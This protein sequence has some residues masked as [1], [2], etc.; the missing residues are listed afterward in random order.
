MDCLQGWLSSKIG[1]AEVDE[2]MCPG[3]SPDGGKCTYKLSIHEIKQIVSC[4][5]FEKYE[6]FSLR[7]FG[8]QD[9]NCRFC[10]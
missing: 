10:T 1:D 6:R 2:M 5:D 7:K 4:E 8:E 9:E 3:M